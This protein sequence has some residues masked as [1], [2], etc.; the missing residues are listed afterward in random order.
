MADTATPT[1]AQSGGIRA[2]ASNSTVDSVWHRVQTWAEQ[3]S[4]S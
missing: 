1:S 2:E 3:V 4:R